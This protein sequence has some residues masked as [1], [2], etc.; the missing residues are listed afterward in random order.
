MFKTTQGETTIFDQ[1]LE[2]E[3]AP[4]IYFMGFP[5]L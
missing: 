2:V 5:F 1:I 4:S 3:V